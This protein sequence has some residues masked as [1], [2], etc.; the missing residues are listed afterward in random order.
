MQIRASSSI[1]GVCWSRREGPGDVIGGIDLNLQSWLSGTGV[2]KDA[3]VLTNN[4]S[5]CVNHTRCTKV[6]GL[7]RNSGACIRSV[8]VGLARRE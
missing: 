2:N 3:R 1:L 4:P 8:V 6:Q 7:A 5:T